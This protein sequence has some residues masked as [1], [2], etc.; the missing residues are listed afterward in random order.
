VIYD[1][2]YGYLAQEDEDVVYWRSQIVDP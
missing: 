1:E 2:I